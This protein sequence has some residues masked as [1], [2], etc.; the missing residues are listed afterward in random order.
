MTTRA[1]LI[2][3]ERLPGFLDLVNRPDSMRGNEVV[4]VKDMRHQIL[5]VVQREF[6]YPCVENEIAEYAKG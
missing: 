4:L 2:S 1:Y 5:V 6:D 3:P